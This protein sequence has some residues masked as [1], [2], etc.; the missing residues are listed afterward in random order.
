MVLNAGG[1]ELH[2]PMQGETPALYAFAFTPLFSGTISRQQF[3]A[4]RPDRPGTYTFVIEAKDVAGNRATR[5][6]QVRAV[7]QGETPGSLDGAPQVDSDLP[8]D[9]AVDLMVTTNVVAWF[10]EPVENVN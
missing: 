8:A 6:I 4:F 10:S 3:R 7:E 2:T 9:G 1:R 5:R